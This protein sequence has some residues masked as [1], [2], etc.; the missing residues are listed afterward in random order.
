MFSL[1]CSFIYPCGL[2]KWV[3]TTNKTHFSPPFFTCWCSSLSLVWQNQTLNVEKNTLGEQSHYLLITTLS[4]LKNSFKES[5]NGLRAVS[6]EASFTF[7]SPKHWSLL[8]EVRHL[9]LQWYYIYWYKRG[10][11][12]WQLEIY[13]LKTMTI[14]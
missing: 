10:D 1:T 7:S 12:Y 6:F 3:S 4:E 14:L 9:V 11:N 5:Q 13:Y 8:G 2:I